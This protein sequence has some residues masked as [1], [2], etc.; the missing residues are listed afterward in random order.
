[1]LQ[2]GEVIKKLGG[3]ERGGCSGGVARLLREGDD[4]L[5]DDGNT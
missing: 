5:N 2:E 4:R 3:K 1:M